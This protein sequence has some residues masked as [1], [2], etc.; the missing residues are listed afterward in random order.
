V[1]SRG[2][3]TALVF[4]AILHAA[5]AFAQ[6][7]PEPSMAREIQGQ[8]VDSSATVSFFN[9]QI[10]VLRARVAGRMPAERALG[11]ER[12]LN[13]LLAQGVSTPIAARPFEG[14]AMMT[15]GS[16]AVFMLTAADVDDLAGETLDRVS[17]QTVI[18][19]ERAFSEAEDARRP[20]VV[21]R[22]AASAVGAI[23]ASCLALWLLGRLRRQMIRVLDVLARRPTASLDEVSAA[24]I[25]D[26]QGHVLHG[27]FTAIDLVVIYGV[28]TF[29]LRQFPYTRPWGE[30]MSG[31]LIS[32]VETLAL[33]GVRAVPGLFTVVL[34]L[35]AARFLTSVA[36]AWFTALEHGRV[37]ARWIHPETAQPT[38][39]LVV[40]LVWI[41]AIV[42]AYPYM[43]GSQ[44]DAFKGV[45]VFVGLMVTF[46][47]SGL[48]NQV[49]SGFMITYSRA[50]RVGDFVKI[51]DVEGTVT[52]VGVLSTKIRS[53]LR[54][55]ITIPNA[56]VVSHTTTDYSRLAESDGVF[57]PTSVTIGYDAPWRQ[58]HALLLLAA[59]RT[60]G[61][62]VNPQP[63]VLQT[64]L[65]DFYVKY[66]LFVSLQDQGRRAIIID[67][68][69]ASI[70]DAF[71]EHGVQIMSPN[72]ML[73]PSAPKVVPKEQWF[74]TPATHAP[75]P[76]EIVYANAPDPANESTPRLRDLAE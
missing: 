41:L 15:V 5:A 32:T 35:V 8:R 42:V 43:P 36:R 21:L 44:T 70:Q 30:S 14:G 56:V 65:E 55:E 46:G 68:L 66:T 27:L 60:P 67:A 61:V 17:A 52:H 62:R 47:S 22:G 29:V 45:S 40:T 1:A 53:I 39:R 19:L 76:A 73:D 51:G 24:H 20:S 54:E 12:L 63:V 72:Y 64:G 7:P 74:A 2:I 69:H 33:G 25:K 9:R 11:A 48:V 71:N 31:F 28:T 3:S 59:Q 13:D 34:I 49:M 23:I 16:R 75:S 38:R 4:I 37:T 10:V 50:L 18:R 6:T 26:L 57:T 58:V